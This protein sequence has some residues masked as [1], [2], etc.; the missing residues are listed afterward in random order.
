MMLPDFVYIFYCTLITVDSHKY[1]VNLISKATTVLHNETNKV[2][3]T[4]YLIR[5]DITVHTFS[6]KLSFPSIG[7]DRSNLQKL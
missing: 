6:I 5:Q 7:Q 3:K 2:G 4:H 1:Q